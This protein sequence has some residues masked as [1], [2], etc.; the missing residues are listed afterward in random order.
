MLLSYRIVIVY[1]ILAAVCLVIAL[2]VPRLRIAAIAGCM[3]LGFLLAWGMIQRWRAP[4]T[5]AGE[6]GPVRGS[7]TSPVVAVGA[8]PLESLQASDLQL[9]GSGAPFQL[10]GRVAN[11]STS[12]QLRSVTV[13]VTRRDCFAAALDP[14]GC[15][16]FFENRQW[17]SLA[18]PP[19]QEREFA[20][21]FWARGSAPRARGT[22]RDSFKIVAATGA[23]AGGATDNRA[24][25]EN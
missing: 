7:P 5:A 14:S 4:E 20:A 13:Q 9:T 11:T 22:L 21:S 2:T 1:W 12:L 6:A 8:F 17:I 24:K 23:P 16:R 18:V 10:R 15:E 19:Q 25:I 3:V